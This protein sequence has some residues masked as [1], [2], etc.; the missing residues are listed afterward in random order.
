MSGLYCNFLISTTLTTGY[1]EIENLSKDLLILPN[2]ATAD[3][4]I[5]LNT[6]LFELRKLEIRN[7]LGQIILVK[8]LTGQNSTS[9]DV[10]QLNSVIYFITIVGKVSGESFTK[11]LVIN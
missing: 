5:T 1:P 6:A 10:H 7:Y 2:P 11:K 4:S 8:E 9:L 3:V